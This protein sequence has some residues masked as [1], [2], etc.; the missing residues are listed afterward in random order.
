MRYV[1]WTDTS[2]SFG[3]HLVQY[4]GTDT[5]FEM[6]IRQLDTL[7]M[8]L[9]VVQGD[10][11]ELYWRV[12]SIS[13]LDSVSSSTALQTRVVREIIVGIEDE[14]SRLPARFA[15]H[16]N[17]PNPFNPATTIRYDLVQESKVLLRIY[18]ALGQEIRTLVDRV[19]P[20]G[21]K[22]VVWDSKDNAGRSVASGVYI[23]RLS[24]GRF[25]KSRKMLFVR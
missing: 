21:Y 13:G 11:I 1:V 15:L 14:N 2:Q 5:T 4:E 9:G 10:S 16:Q 22:S 25:V 18:N 17:Y 7:L 6:E 3:L 24:A 8:E 12:L 23:C 20:A 19:E